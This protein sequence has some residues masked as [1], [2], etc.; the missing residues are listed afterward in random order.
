MGYQ[1]DLKET[2]NNLNIKF[3]D[4]FNY[5]IIFSY[6][7]KDFFGFAKQTS[8][9]TVEDEINMKLS[10]VLNTKVKI[11]G[12]SRTD[13]GVHALNQVA[14]FFLD[15]KIEDKL[16]LNDFLYKLNKVID[17]DIYIKSIKRV[18]YKFSARFSLHS[19]EYFYLINIKEYDPLRKDYELFVKDLDIEKIKEA[20]KLF[21]GKHDFRNFT[22]KKEDEL[23]NF[24]RTIYKIKIQKINS[25]R[26]KIIFSADGF[27]RYEI[28]K[29]VGT[30][31]AYSFNKITLDEILKYLN[32]NKET[33]NIVPFQA[34]SEGLY[35]SRIKY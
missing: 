8:K 35:L 18:Y 27:M 25:K 2:L 26:I 11:Y 31:I 19:K 32:P 23:L 12:S 20:S 33:R 5:K 7:G 14:N 10:L 21:L 6:D 3:K 29:I 4:K 16:P 15:K 9:R 34:K 17:K 22:S 30:L 24:E 13:K 28:R 1:D